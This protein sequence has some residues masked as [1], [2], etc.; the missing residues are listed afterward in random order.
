MATELDLMQAP[1][2]GITLIE[3]AAGTGKT[4]AI[5]GLYARLL[6]ECRLPVEQILVVTYTNAA[7]AELRDRVRGRLA[8]VREAFATGSAEDDY[9]R[10]LLERFPAHAEAEARLRQALLD[11]DRAAIFT[12][13]GF[14][15]RVLA[16]TAFESGLPFENELLTDQQ[17]LVQE[18]ADDFWRTRVQDAPP[19]LL[20]YLVGRGVSPGRLAKEISDWAT[21]PFIAVRGPKAPA[22]DAVEAPF[23]QRFRDARAEWLPAREEV[24]ELL[25]KSPALNR[26]RYRPGS[27]E[28]WGASMD[29]YLSDPPGAW[30]EGF[31]KFTSATLAA[32]VKKGAEPPRHPFFDLCGAL[33]TARTARE[34]GFAAR[35]AALRAEL[36]A[37]ARDELTR[38][39][40]ERRLLAYDDLLANLHGALRRDGDGSLRRRVRETFQAALIDEFQDTDPLQYEIFDTVYGRTAAPVFLV[41]DPKQAIYG[42]RG[43]DIFSYLRARRGADRVFTLSTNWRSVPPLVAAVNALFDTGHPAFLFEEI[44]FGRAAPAP[45]EMEAL[46]GAGGAPVLRVGLLEPGLNK[47]EAAARAAAW[48][49]AGVAELLGL[50]GGGGATLAGRPAAG[51]DIAVLVRSHGQ[52]SRVREALARLGI[53][54]VQRGRESLFESS[55]AEQVERVM[56][57]VFAP[58]RPGLLRAALATDLFG[59]DA[60]EI[61]RLNRDDALFEGQAELFGRLH[62]LWRDSGFSAMAGELLAREAVAERL[63]RCAGGER[64]LTNLRHLVEVLHRESAAGRNT[65]DGLINWL[66]RRRT[67]PPDGEEEY[68]LR[69]ESDEQLVQIVTIH[70]SKGLQYPVV[71]CPFAWDGGFRAGGA[72]DPF[73]YHDPEE[74]Y[75]PVLELEPGLRPGNRLHARREAL[76]EDLRLLYVALTRAR[77]R[78]YL[79]WGAVGGADTSA[80]GWLLHPPA[81]AGSPGAVDDMKGRLAVLE[82]GAM[83]SRL[84]RLAEGDSDRVRVE[85]VAAPASSAP[86]RPPT[87]PWTPLAARTARRTPGSRARVTSFSAL[88]SGQ[89]PLDQ[90]DHDG[91]AEPP[92]PAAQGRGDIFGFPRGTRA[93]SC[94]HAVFERLDFAG[95][96]PETVEGLVRTTLAGFGFDARWV[97]AVCRT[98]EAVLDSEL[99]PGRNVRLR[100][101]GSDRRL[102]EMEFHLPLHRLER[103]GLVRLLS[104]HGLAKGEAMGQALERLQFA[105]VAG[106]LRGFVDLVFESGGRFHL[107]DY[108]SNW[109]GDETARYRPERL[110]EEIARH[111]YYLQYLLYTVALHRYLGQRLAGYDYDRHFGAVFYIFLRGVDPVADPGA[112]VFRDRPERALVEALDRFLAEGGAG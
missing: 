54:S 51:G 66:H 98:V 105:P 111:D 41:G 77:H 22:L 19:G 9:R 91:D 90:P 38:R 46:S 52:A 8:E 57:A 70:K 101:V 3:A 92:E 95:C 55:E 14:C 4:F 25:L 73:I 96:T 13:H 23:E 80:L 39:K 68:Q 1:L 42:F 40:R 59:W 10:G 83:E 16:D 30:F 62:R 97:P 69:L 12:I 44:G 76:A 87:V 79:N 86:W 50:D 65:M 81:S 104:D 58:G 53:N 102:V 35:H 45:R 71:F 21:R 99:E 27:I 84:A 67:D 103:A 109:L 17:D 85:P 94:L 18:V 48:T 82:P 56:R 34:A 107:A 6:L 33:E 7:T 32:S 24:M 93:G 26:N 78:C 64:R 11:F 89:V 5:T 31:R 72:D 100:G 88:T 2:E 63:L 28:G 112:G 37:Y 74:G 108:K 20:D 61:D 60:G 49:A 110:R 29:A 106:Y 47:G 75:A 15:Q 36:V 43:A